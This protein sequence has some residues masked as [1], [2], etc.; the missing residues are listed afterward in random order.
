MHEHYTCIPSLDLEL[1]VG[2]CTQGLGI[3]PPK[4]PWSAGRTKWQA[5]VSTLG[6]E[7]TEHTV[8]TG[9]PNSC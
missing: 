4:L 6:K 1:N 5:T 7:E 9:E 3:L 8:A 2:N